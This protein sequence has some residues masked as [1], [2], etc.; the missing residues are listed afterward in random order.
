MDMRNTKASLLMVAIFVIA[1]ACSSAA[2]TPATMAGFWEDI[3]HNVTEIEYQNGQYVAVT[4]Y[5]TVSSSSQN[6]LVWSSYE[7]GVLSW[8]YC[9]PA[10]PCMTMQTVSFNGDTL[11]VT[12]KN[13]KGESG[14]MTLSRSEKYI[15]RGTS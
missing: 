12:W 3:D 1:S 15:G 5:Y 8:K 6:S 7:N 10:R 11:E 13:D 4:T 2:P 14:Q 9:P